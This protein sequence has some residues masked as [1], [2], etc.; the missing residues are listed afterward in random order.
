MELILS[1]NYFWPAKL[2]QRGS[3]RMVKFQ[4]QSRDRSRRIIWLIYQNKQ[5]KLSNKNEGHTPN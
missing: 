4:N 1:G 2:G 3:L 5:T